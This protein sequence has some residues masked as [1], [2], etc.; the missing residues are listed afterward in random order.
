MLVKYF[1]KV[2]I[3]PF[4]KNKINILTNR[5]ELTNQFINLYK[6]KFHYSCVLYFIELNFFRQKFHNKKMFT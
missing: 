3:N 5:D 4:L 1:C 6:L 2:N